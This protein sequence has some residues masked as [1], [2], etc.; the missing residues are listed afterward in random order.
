MDEAEHKKLTKQSNVPILAFARYLADR[1]VEV[2][3]R[4]VVVPGITDKEVYLKQLGALL[5]HLVM[6]KHWMYCLI[7]QWES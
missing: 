1:K 5:R 3:I 2:W 7:I 6:S 4:H